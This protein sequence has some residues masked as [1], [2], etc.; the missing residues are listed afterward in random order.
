MAEKAGTA[1]TSVG[2]SAPEP[3]Q[4]EEL[5]PFK[6]IRKLGE[7]GM[8]EVF[9]ARDTRLRRQVAI[10]V[11]APAMTGDKS[12][13]ERFRHEAHAVSALNHPNILTIYD[14]GQQD[15]VHFIAT[16]FVDGRTLRERMLE[17]PLALA[18]ILDITGQVAAA[19]GAAHA[20]GII[21][22]D[23]KP[24]NIMIRKDGYVKVLDFGI[25]KLGERGGERSGADTLVRAP[26]TPGL[27]IGTV[28][29]MSPEQARG[30]PVDPRSDLFSLGVMIYE[31]TAGRMPFG[32]ATPSDVIAA[33]LRH[34]PRSLTEL[35]QN[36]PVE[37][38]QLVERALRKERAERHGSAAEMLA[39]LNRIR[40]DLPE[41][42]LLK[43]TE[44]RD[45]EAAISTRLLP[46][47]SGERATGQ[48]TR[49]RRAID[50]LAVL[51]F[52]NESA[53][54]ETDYLSD[55]ITESI[56][57]SLSLLPKVRVVPR[58][59]VFRY[60][61]TD[62]DPIEIGRSLGVRA[63]VIG[64]VLQ[65]GDSLLFNTELVDV[66]NESQVWGEQYRRGMTDIFA[67]QGE[68]AE[69]ISSQ[70]K[71]KLTGA[72]KKRLRKQ[73]TEN[74]EA[75]QFYLKGRYFVTAKRTEEW[76]KKG[77]EYFQQAIDLDPNYALAYA[78]IA[79]A[80]GFLASSTGG[81]APR[82]AYPKAKAAAEKAL[83]LDKDLAEAHCS[84]GFARLLYDWDFR[85][86]ESAFQRALKLNPNYP[87]AWDGYGFYLKAVGRHDEAIDK[88]KQ[89]LQ[90]DPLSAFAHVSLGYA[91]YYARDYAR[92]I[93]ECQRALAMD[94]HSSFAFRTIGQSQ[95]ALGQ[96][97]KGIEALER[98]VEYSRS[99]SVFE[100][101]LGLAYGTI[102]EKEKA[103]QV[104]HK[105]EARG[106]KTYLSSFDLAMIHLGLGDID[107]TFELLE[108]AYEQ[109][110][111]FIPF[112]N[113][114]PMVD[115]LRSHSRFRELLKQIGF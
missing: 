2:E 1:P 19:L 43:R 44:V 10:K 50:S 77:I 82:E 22:R 25:A 89:A 94:G 80:Y 101:A 28:R 108:N 79:E 111:G 64:R 104:L 93:T 65:V 81:W 54:P 85:G 47:S 57:N 102:G 90:L 62:A 38:D 74:T 78:G 95:L 70:L 86:A 69:E 14:I 106:T 31:L 42:L 20:A 15:E 23:I 29:Y 91:Y 56:I 9:L 40:R 105:L 83:E 84:L 67:L 16:E 107:R 13:V 30:L 115:T 87:T 52:T 60:K 103:L 37:L 75:Y 35:V 33:I 61:T 113:V 48:R 3:V 39:E 97:D 5:G 98:A 92:A 73:Y 8:G 114:E 109:R 7:G 6:I 26:T 45:V 41:F 76:I 49:T 112:L 46:A 51:P 71:L 99:G 88:G 21:H 110:S 11:L 18:E 12:A 17:R 55:G 36:L 72:Q 27:I 63:V 100:S 58:S 34:E 4:F 53:D 68:I 59:T 32:G 66:A 24:E 96:A